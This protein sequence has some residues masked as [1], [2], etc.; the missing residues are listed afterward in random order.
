MCFLSANL[1][2]YFGRSALDAH[3]AFFDVSERPNAIP[4]YAP[5]YGNPSRNG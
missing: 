4:S 2:G 3:N 1:N 5:A